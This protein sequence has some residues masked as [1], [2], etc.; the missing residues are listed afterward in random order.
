[1]PFTP[2]VLAAL[3][4]RHALGLVCSS[5]REAISLAVAPSA[6]CLEL[7][8][9]STLSIATRSAHILLLGAV[10]ERYVLFVEAPHMLLQG[11]IQESL[12]LTNV[13]SGIRA[14]AHQGGSGHQAGADQVGIWHQG[15]G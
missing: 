13:L 12:L 1:M 7:C 3:T 4:D 6:A 11:A 2:L 8:A 15:T 14:G 9:S 10:W 5:L